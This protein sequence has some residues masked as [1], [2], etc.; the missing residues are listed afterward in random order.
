M[1]KKSVYGDY[2]CGNKISEYGLE[3]GRVDY[4]TFA[5]AFDAVMCNDI[6]TRTDGICGYWEQVNGII[7][8]SEEIEEIEQEIENIQEQIEEI[9]EG[10]EQSKDI[11]IDELKN[12]LEKLEYDKEQ[13][14][15]EQENSYNEEIYQYYIV[16]DNGA[17][18]IQ[19]FTNQPL[20][21]NEDLDLYVWGITHYGT[22]WSYVLTEIPCNV[23]IEK[24]MEEINK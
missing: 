7:D 12:T 13:L 19:E 17:S 14:E 23:G 2:F 24:V 3:K 1:F 4:S 15:E 18:I 21:Y 16:D 8:N 6:M 11:A 5:K 10:E 22:A 9:E 20:F